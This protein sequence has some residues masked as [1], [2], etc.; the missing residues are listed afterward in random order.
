MKI[1]AQKRRAAFLS[2]IFQ[3]NSKYNRYVFTKIYE[4][5]LFN[6][7]GAEKNSESK[8][9]PGSSLSQ[10]QELINQLPSLID[11]YSIQSILDVPCGDL[12]W[13]SKVELKNVSYIGAD[14][15]K[16]LVELNKSKYTKDNV[17]FCQLNI[18]NDNLPKVDLVICRDLFVHLSNSQV[19]KSVENIKKSGA[20][21]LLTTSFRE[22]INDVSFE[23]LGHWR[24]LNLEK[25][26]FY[27]N[28]SIDSIFENCT[29]KE[30]RYNDKYLLL[31]NL[32]QMNIEK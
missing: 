20:K 22:K 3:N 7:R 12:N 21:Y 9:G 6:K 13:M 18:I 2:K 29:E 4:Q 28:N 24:P 31:Y 25:T 19:F 32:K 11:K 17:R 5:N 16:E 23:V 30:M 26:P 8:S 10:T 27:F 14:I 15:V 1:Y